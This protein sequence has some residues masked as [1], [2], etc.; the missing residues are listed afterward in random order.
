MLAAGHAIDLIIDNNGGEVQV[1]PGSMDKV[2][3]AYSG[4]IPVTHDCD[5][6]QGWFGQF[7]TGGIGEGSAMQTMECMRAIKSIEQTGTADVAD[8][9][10]LIF[11]NLHVLEALIQC[12]RHDFV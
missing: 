1:S 2:I 7:D 4:C 8:Q 3:A 5:D 10:N 12:A 9:D 11:L 6:G